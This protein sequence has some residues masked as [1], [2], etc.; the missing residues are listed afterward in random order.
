M[1]IYT[2]FSYFLTPYPLS[3][4]KINAT[5]LHF[6][7]FWGPPP[8]PVQMSFQ[9]R[10]S[11]VLLKMACHLNIHVVVPETTAKVATNRDKRRRES[12]SSKNAPASAKQSSTNRTRVKSLLALPF[13]FF[14]PMCKVLHRLYISSGG[15]TKSKRR[16]A[17]RNAVRKV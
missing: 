16:M 17:P 5:S 9:Y 2:K 3:L 13:K 6:V 11:A 7:C 12:C 8:P 15:N 10:P 4:S 14:N 1:T